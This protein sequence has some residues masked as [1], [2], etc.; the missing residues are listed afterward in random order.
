MYKLSPGARTLQQVSQEMKQR[1]PQICQLQYY[2]E[3]SKV[4]N[5]PNLIESLQKKG[6][7]S[8]KLT[9]KQEISEI[10]EVSKEDSNF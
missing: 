3:G 10:E 8:L 9:A 1:F 7:N 4:K 2:H 6:V 5:L